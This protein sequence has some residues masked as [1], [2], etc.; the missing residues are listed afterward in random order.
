LFRVPAF[1]FAMA[2][3]LDFKDIDC[4][5]EFFDG[6]SDDSSSL[7]SRKIENWLAMKCRSLESRVTKIESWM[8]GRRRDGEELLVEEVGLRRDVGLVRGSRILSQCTLL[9]SSDL[10]KAMA[11]SEQLPERDA[12]DVKPSLAPCEQLSGR[13]AGDV[14]PSLMALSEQLPERDAGDV[15]P[16]WA[17]CEQ[18]PKAMALSEQ[19]P[20]RDAGDVK[21][22]LAPCEQISER[23]AGERALL[24]PSG[25]CYDAV[26][27]FILRVYGINVRLRALAVDKLRMGRDEKWTA[28]QI[29]HFWDDRFHGEKSIMDDLRTL[30]EKN[31]G[32]SWG[33]S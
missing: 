16:S 27:E 1:L 9:A 3:V 33:V 25:V 14:K 11:P 5:T 32:R 24:W 30:L 26:E 18:P 4:D 23:D 20:E 22:S 28:E 21:P 12:G 15:K 2:V 17:P 10:P 19:L 29:M 6:S 7:K 8:E 13:D 31:A